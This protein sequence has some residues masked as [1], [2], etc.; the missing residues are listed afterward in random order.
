MGLT[1]EKHPNDSIIFITIKPPVVVPEDPA[2][3]TEATLDFQKKQGGMV[4][5]ITDYT[6]VKLTFSDVVE[7]MASD[8]AFS[9]PNIISVM[10]GSDAMVRMVADSFRQAQYGGIDVTLVAT[11]DEALRKAKQL[12]ADRA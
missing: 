1:I 9:D 8:K 7:G 5:R 2:E 10:I 12:L 3:A 6:K 11:R 4:C